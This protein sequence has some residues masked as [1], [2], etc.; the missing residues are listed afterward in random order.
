MLGAGGRQANEY[1]SFIFYHNNTP[2]WA[3][4]FKVGVSVS[5]VMY[6]LTFVLVHV[7]VCSCP[8]LSRSSLTHI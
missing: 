5:H 2:K 7:T 1:E 4:T 8:Y 3:E 6:H